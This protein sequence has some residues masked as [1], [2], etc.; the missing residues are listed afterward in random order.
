MKGKNVNKVTSESL[1]KWH[2]FLWF[3]VFYYIDSWIHIGTNSIYYINSWSYW[4]LAK[5]YFYNSG[6]SIVLTL[7]MF[8]EIVCVYLNIH[9][10]QQLIVECLSIKH[11]VGVGWTVEPETSTLLLWFTLRLPLSPYNGFQGTS[12][13]ITK[14][15]PYNLH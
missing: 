1:E 10:I 9:F 4:L 6:S 5:I 2:W 13:Y 14:F 7:L 15:E 11:W 8:F 12:T 3:W